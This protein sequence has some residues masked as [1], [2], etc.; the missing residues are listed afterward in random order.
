[1]VPEC[2]PEMVGGIFVEPNQAILGVYRG[3][4]SLPRAMVVASCG[5]ESRIH[6]L[7]GKTTQVKLVACRGMDSQREPT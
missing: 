1:M 5:L 7:V 4:V 3:A 6:G 2:I